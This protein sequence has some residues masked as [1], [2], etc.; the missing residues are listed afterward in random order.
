LKVSSHQEGSAILISFVIILLFGALGLGLNLILRQ[1]LYID[2]KQEITFETRQ[3]LY[4]EADIIINKLL[5]NETPI[6]DSE[7]D[8]V[9]EYLSE[10]GGN[11][12]EMDLSDVSSLINPNWIRKEIIEETYLSSILFEGAVMD[13]VQQYRY[14]NGFG[15]NIEEFYKDFFTLDALE[16]LLSPYSYANINTTDE[17]ALM[18]L[19]EIRKGNNSSA[20]TFRAKVQ[21][22]RMDKKIVRPSELRV[23]LFPDHDDL[24]PFIS[25]LPAFNIHFLAPDTLKGIL[26]YKYGEKLLPH[27]ET[28]YQKIMSLR[29]NTEISPKQLTEIIS[30]D[31]IDHPVYQ[32]LG[33]KTWFWKI[34]LTIDKT[35]LRV[36]CAVYPQEDSISSIDDSI[37]SLYPDIEKYSINIIESQFIRN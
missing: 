19:Y 31:D 30:E 28:S 18:K 27:P 1:V 26:N 10:K 32:Y 33:T 11:E 36:I 24:F 20:E 2:K 17:F 22:L 8:S 7:L 3:K 29:S 25:A 16:E 6:A 21:K 37:E 4:K 34:V 5:E 14:D 23:V 35:S 12:I 13:D 15:I 9:W